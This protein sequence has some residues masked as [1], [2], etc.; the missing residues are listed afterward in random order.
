MR[1]FNSK[2]NVHHVFTT[3]ASQL[4][5]VPVPTGAVS[6]SS[7][8]STHINK[9]TTSTIIK[10]RQHGFK[11]MIYHAIQLVKVVITSNITCKL[12]K[13]HPT[14]VFINDAIEK[15]GS[16]CQSS[17]CRKNH[18]FQVN[19]FAP[20][21]THVDLFVYNVPDLVGSNFKLQM[22]HPN[23]FLPGVFLL[24]AK[25]VLNTISYGDCTYLIHVPT[26][27]YLVTMVAMKTISVKNI[28]VLLL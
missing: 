23:W 21:L 20:K 4:L 19:I 27:I 5:T 7:H 6:D 10:S 8:T 25:N 15:I 9:T 22:G 28:F 3:T 16:T 1:K 2:T 24:T 26:Y 18:H 17:A 11:T 14:H 12:R 13:F